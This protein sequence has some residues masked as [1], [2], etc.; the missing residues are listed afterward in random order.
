MSNE[1]HNRGIAKMAEL[2]KETC[3][4]LIETLQS[5]APDFT[6]YVVEFAFGDVLNRPG[7]DVKTRELCTVS[8]LS[9]MATAPSQLRFHIGAAR[10]V[11]C[12][13][14]EVLEAIIQMVLYAGF[15]AALNA[16]CAAKEVFEKETSTL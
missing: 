5:V 4:R 14:E 8:A 16:L 10:N 6:K 13:R 2:D 9:A 15:P 1:L 3:D 12:T 7:L 11:G